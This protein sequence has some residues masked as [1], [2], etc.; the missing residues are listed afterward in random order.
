LG[1]I[2][3]ILAK[4]HRESLRQ[5]PEYWQKREEDSRRARNKVA[6]ALKK[7]PDPVKAQQLGKAIDSLTARA[8][9]I[10]IRNEA[11]HMQ[12]GGGGSS[13]DPWEEEE[14]RRRKKKRG[15]HL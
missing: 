8:A 11:K 9:G 7:R 3:K 1:T 10:L 6:A 14:R 4:N 15:L 13:Y 2:E 12:G 5:T